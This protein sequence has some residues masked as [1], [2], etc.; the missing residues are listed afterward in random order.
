MGSCEHDTEPSDSTQGGNFI[1]GVTI[2][3]FRWAVSW[4]ISIHYHFDTV[5]HFQKTVIPGH[6]LTRFIPD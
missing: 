4:Q 1:H 6:L 3:L 2:T 5:L